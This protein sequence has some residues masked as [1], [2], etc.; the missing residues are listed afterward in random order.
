MRGLFLDIGSTFTKLLAVDTNTGSILGRA[1]AATTAGDDVRWGIEAAGAALAQRCG[2]CLDDFEYRRACSSAAGGLSVVALGLAP[3]FT[4]EAARRAALGAGAKVTEVFG[5]PLSEADWARIEAGRPDLILLCGGTDG[6]DESTVRHNV[7]VLCRAVRREA[8]IIYAGNRRP[9]AELAQALRAAGYDV[10]VADNVLPEL[11][12]LHLEPVRAAIREVFLRR[13]VQ[14][15]GLDAV[16]AWADGPIL[17]TPL[18]VLQGVQLLAEGCLGQTGW[19]SLLVV[20]VGGATTDVHSI[21][22]EPPPP[23][24]WIRRGLPELRSKRTVEGDLGLRINAESLLQTAEKAG[25]LTTVGGERL[26][27]E[28]LA[29]LRRWAARVSCQ[30]DWIPSTEEEAGLDAILAR[31]AVELAVR[32][33]AGTVEELPAPTGRAFRQ[34]G[35]D[36]SMVQ[37]VIGT[38]G[39]FGHTNHPRRLLAGAVRDPCDPSSLRPLAPRFWVDRAGCLGAAGLLQEADPV[40]AFWLASGYLEEV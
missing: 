11:H 20:D 10:T 29:A 13:I 19:G 3:E 25:L 22:E 9:A 17:P 27:E 18:A 33:H 26:P 28:S 16:A 24:G 4:A 14:A 1:Q 21:A 6:G 31:A 2:L 34:Q 38:G 40:A 23:P 39:V 15:K 12:R 30:T 35:K 37:H 36:L 5:G 32:R 8:A 7:G